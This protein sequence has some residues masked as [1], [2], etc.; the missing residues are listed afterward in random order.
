MTLHKHTLSLDLNRHTN[1]LTHYPQ[2]SDVIKNTIDQQIH[3]HVTIVPHPPQH[4]LIVKTRQ[5]LRYSYANDKYSTIT[6][7]LP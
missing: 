1:Q 7:K 4:S 2:I 6:D 5:L 3:Q